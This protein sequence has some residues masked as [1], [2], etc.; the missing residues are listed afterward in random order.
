MIKESIE[1]FI[2]AQNPSMY[3]AVIN[4]A[5][6]QETWEELVTF[7]LMARQTLK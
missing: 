3:M 5:Q 7:L 4:I 6:T 1:S 2:K